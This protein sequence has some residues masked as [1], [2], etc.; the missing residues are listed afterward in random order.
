MLYPPIQELVEL[1][2][3]CA[4][5]PGWMEGARY[6]FEPAERRGTGMART[7]RPSGEKS[8]LYY[9]VIERDPPQLVAAARAACRLW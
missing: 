9:P 3:L 8:P 4:T 1:H 2:A 6:R 5:R 7:A